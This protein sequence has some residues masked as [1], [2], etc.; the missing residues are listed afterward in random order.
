MAKLVNIKPERVFK[1]FED[2]SRI[3]RGSGNMERIAEFCVEFAKSKN[4][5][6]VCDKANNVIIYKNKFLVKN[7]RHV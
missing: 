2:I 5:K 6:V 4:L 3:P 7:K 1:Y